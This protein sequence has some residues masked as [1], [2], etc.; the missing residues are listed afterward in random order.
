MEAAAPRVVVVGGGVSGLS[1]ALSILNTLPTCKLTVVSDK[2]S[3]HTTGD[4]AAGMWAPFLV[5]DTPTDD[6]IKWATASWVQFM[7][8]YHSGE[9]WGVS[10]TPG[11]VVTDTKQPPECWR[12]IPIG[13]TT[14]SEDQCRQYGQQYQS[15]YSFTTLFAEASKFLPKLRAEIE[16]NG[17]VFKKQCVDSLEKAASDADVIINCTG[18]GA[19]MLVTDTDMVPYRGQVIRVSAPW[20]NRFFCDDSETTF[21]YI[22]PNK[23]CV[24]LGGTHDE[25]DWNL[26]V[27][28]KTSQTILERCC[29]MMPSLKDAKVIKTAVGLRPGRL[30]GVRLE[31]REL[32]LADRTVPVVHNYGHGGCGVTLMWGC[33]REVA[34]IVEDIVGHSKASV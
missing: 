5:G 6:I 10:L 9:D 34:S 22:L 13:Y 15:G 20:V 33:A 26:D 29:K 8:W 19:A 32:R 14:L 28:E 3:P 23:D 12:D 25:N 21:C 24:L 2:F 4:V 30:S 11:T 31:K 18:L 1:S 17:G 16:R 7:E 27:D